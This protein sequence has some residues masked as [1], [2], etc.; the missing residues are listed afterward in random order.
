MI[1]ALALSSATSGVAVS[2][3]WIPDFTDLEQLA[4]N[5]CS[6]SISKLDDTQATVTAV[7]DTNKLQT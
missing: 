2:R 3:G 5:F 4:A 6:I 7:P 1:A